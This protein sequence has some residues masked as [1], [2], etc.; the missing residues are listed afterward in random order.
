M[1]ATKSRSSLSWT[2]LSRT[3]SLPEHNHEYYTT[4][5]WVLHKINGSN[6]IKIKFKLNNPFPRIITTRKQTWVL[7]LNNLN[8]SEGKPFSS[9]RL[10]F[11][12]PRILTYIPS[13]V[14]RVKTSCLL[15]IGEEEKTLT[16]SWL[17]K[18][19]IACH[20]NGGRYSNTTLVV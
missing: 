1:E 7:L 5:S 19:K 9:V 16:A 18:K 12:R 2:I 3:S 15:S 20:I 8:T 14:S 10:L 6:Q 4:Q 13:V 11:I 17:Q